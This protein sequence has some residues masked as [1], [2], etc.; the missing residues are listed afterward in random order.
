MKTMH[1]IAGTS[2]LLLLW[3]AFTL[4]AALYGLWLQ[5][6]ASADHVFLPERE[7]SES[8]RSN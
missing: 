4:I 3:G 8:D 6:L 2:A 5:P 7:K 1:L